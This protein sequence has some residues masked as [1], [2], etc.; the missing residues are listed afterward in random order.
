MRQATAAQHRAHRTEHGKEPKQNW[1]KQR[2]TNENISCQDA[3]N[4]ATKRVQK[5]T[6]I[7]PTKFRLSGAGEY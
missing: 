5:P 7:A 2:Q 3:E 4:Y 6:G 1:K